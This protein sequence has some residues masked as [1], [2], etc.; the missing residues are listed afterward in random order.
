MTLND[1]IRDAQGIAS[2][3]SSGDIPLEHDI[4]LELLQAKDGY[5][6]SA[7]SKFLDEAQIVKRPLP[8][9]SDDWYVKG[10]KPLAV[11]V[12]EGYDKAQY[13]HA[14]ADGYE[15]AKRDLGWDEPISYEDFVKAIAKNI[16]HRPFDWSE[17]D[18]GTLQVIVSCIER[19]RANSILSEDHCLRLETFLYKHCRPQPHWK[20]TE[21]QMEA[22]WNL[23]HY[24][25]NLYSWPELEKSIESLYKDLKK[26]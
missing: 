12:P 18:E 1:L 15:R 17:R 10:V 9:N 19:A 20:P 22:L 4:E 14:Y 2:Q 11:S 3:L 25:V 23:M 21:E 5:K 8:L 13:I 16:P 26:L 24:A 7:L 6:V